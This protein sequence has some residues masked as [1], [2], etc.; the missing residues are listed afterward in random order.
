[1]LWTG[2]IGFIDDYLKIVR[3]KSQGLV[4]RWKLIGQ[5]T[6]GVA[7]GVALILWPLAPDLP[8]T[9]T[10]LPVFKYI[11]L[12]LPP[13]LYLLFVTVVVTGSSNA[14]NLTDGLDGLGG[15]DGDPRGHVRGVC[16]C[17]RPHRLDALPVR[18]LPARLAGADHLLRGARRGGARLPVVQ[19]APRAGVHGRHRLTRDRRRDGG[20]RDHAEGRV[21]V[22]HC[23]RGV[24]RGSRVRDAAGVGVS[25]AQA[26]LRQ[27]VRRRPQGVSHGAAAP[28]LREAGLGRAAGRDAVL[29]PGGDVRG[30]RARDAEG[31]MIPQAWR[32]TG[33]VAVIGLGK[34]GVAATRLLA[35][36]GVRVYARDASEHPYGGDALESLRTLG[37]VALDVGRHDLARIRG[38]ADP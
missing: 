36:E 32:G 1:M 20:G 18:V 3:G 35:R 29:H 8:P 26:A 31:A 22:A 10:Q 17:I 19:R 21:P 14:V 4:A 30:D 9:S 28:S 7:L 6:F 5:V 11:L 12:V 13:P 27:G 37:G 23:R 2:A 24:R 34:S 16:L 25:L 33:V 15:P 38:A